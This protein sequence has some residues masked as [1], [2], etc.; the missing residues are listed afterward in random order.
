MK[1]RCDGLAL[2]E[3][4]LKV[5]KAISI[6][7][8]N[9]VLEGIK[10]TAEDGFL[11]LTATDLEITISKKIVADVKIEGEVLVTGKVFAE[12]VK[13]LDHE[14]IELECTDSKNIAIHY[15]DNQVF[16]KLMDVSAYPAIDEVEQDSEI[17]LKKDDLKDIINKTVFSASVEDGRPIL[18]GCLFEVVCDNLTV[19][20]LDGYRLALCNKKIVS[21]TNDKANYVIP[22]RSLAEISKFIDEGDDSVKLIFGKDKLYVNINNTIVISRL[23]MSDFINYR[24]IL[25]SGFTTSVTFNKAQFYESVY[26]ATIMSKA[27]KNNLVKVE[28]KENTLLI[29]STSEMGVVH[30]TI[31]ADVDGKETLICFNGKYLLDFLNVV[32]DEFIRMNVKTSNSPCIFNQVEGDDYL[33]LILPMRITY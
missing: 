32:D 22:A 6:K 25:T 33:F 10:L 28:V 26:R 13:S 3:A 20:A 21:G 29:D 14:I 5:A 15:G 1:L 27:G 23:I 17:E 24:N 16:I 18:K 30:E 11:T 7:K 4:V 19:V 31:P 9:T 8:N 2:S 12:Y